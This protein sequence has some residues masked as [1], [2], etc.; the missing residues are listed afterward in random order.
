VP[1]KVCHT[2]RKLTFCVG[3][4]VKRFDQT[5]T[6][7]KVE[8][9]ADNSGRKKMAVRVK[10]DGDKRGAYQYPFLFVEV[11]KLK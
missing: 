3:D 10:W 5:G 2:E 6:V 4:R 1:A 7:T 8:P 11:K 9:G